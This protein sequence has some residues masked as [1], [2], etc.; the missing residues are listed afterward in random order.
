MDIYTCELDPDTKTVL[1]LY[2]FTKVQNVDVIKNNIINGIWNCAVIKAS[3]IADPLQVAVA[4]NKAVVAEKLNSMVTK[5][6]FAEILYNLSLTK[7]ISQSLN[8]FGIDKDNSLLFCFLITDEK[9]DTENIISKVEG[10]QRPISDLAKY[11]NMKDIKS[12]YKLNNL[13]GNEDIVDIIVSKMVTKN[14]ISH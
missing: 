2:L 13:K 4:A 3:L 1:R 10:E 9:N 5:T 6:V 8:K 7:N 11:S 14:F 12:L